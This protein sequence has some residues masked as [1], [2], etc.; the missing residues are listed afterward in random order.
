MGV[1]LDCE[2][3]LKRGVPRRPVWTEQMQRQNGTHTAAVMVPSVV[4]GRF[5]VSFLVQLEQLVTQPVQFICAVLLVVGEHIVQIRI[6]SF[7]KTVVIA[8]LWVKMVFANGLVMGRIIVQL[9]KGR[10]CT[11]P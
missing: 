10:V 11:R 5:L 9:R 1:V 8:F 2:C 7:Q 4:D 3:Y 6:N